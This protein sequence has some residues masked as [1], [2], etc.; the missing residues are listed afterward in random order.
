[1]SQKTDDSQPDKYFVPKAV[2][3]NF[4]NEICPTCKTNDWYLNGLCIACHD[5]ED[6]NADHYHTMLERLPVKL[7]TAKFTDSMA[8]NPEMVKYRDTCKRSA[9][10]RESLFFYGSVGNGKTTLLALTYK[11]LA[12]QG[13]WVR[14]VNV[15]ELMESIRQGYGNRQADPISSLVSASR[16]G[17]SLFLDDMGAERV[18]SGESVSFVEE[19]L[20]RLING[21]YE[22]DGHVFVGS[23]KDIGEI[24]D[25][26]GDRIASRLVEMCVQ[27]ENTLPDYRLGNVRKQG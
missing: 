2:G 6:R 21:V 15:P 4:K 18:K 17:A 9:D 22:A 12:K 19:Q 1:M 3:G 26:V 14:W 16:A 7:Q 23:N 20:Y 27:L 13:K 11:Y 25:H 5:K 24:S 8:Q 10:N